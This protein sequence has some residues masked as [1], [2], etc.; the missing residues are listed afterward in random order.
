MTITWE[1][2]LAFLKKRQGV[3]DGVAITGGEPLLRGGIRWNRIF[4]TA[5]PDK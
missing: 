2:V 4:R 5:N 1:Q 3:L